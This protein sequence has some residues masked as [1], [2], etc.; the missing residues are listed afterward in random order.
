[1]VTRTWLAMYPRIKAV[2]TWD[3]FLDALCSDHPY[4]EYD[5]C[6]LCGKNDSLVEVDCGPWAAGEHTDLAIPATE[7]RS[8]GVLFRDQ[9][10]YLVGVHCV[11]RPC[12]LEVVQ[13]GK[14]P[15][16]PDD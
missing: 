11:C 10:S 14:L 13:S 5:Q 7:T 1:M 4:P 9:I 2:L 16:A 12:L 8:W 15:W 3:A 6:I